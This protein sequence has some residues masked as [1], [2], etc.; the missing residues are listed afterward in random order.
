MKYYKKI[1][2]I[3]LTLLLF[4]GG[5]M[6]QTV[7][8][9]P[10][11]G[12][13]NGATPFLTIQAAVDSVLANAATPDVVQLQTNGIHIQTASVV[14]DMIGGDFT[15]IGVGGNAVIVGAN[16][17]AL[18]TDI[19]EGAV[20][21]AAT[22]STVLFEN[23]T[24]IPPSVLATGDADGGPV[25]DDVNG[26]SGLVM[27]SGSVNTSVT[28]RNLVITGNNN[29][30]A[31]T[32]IDGSLDWNGVT[33]VSVWPAA[34]AR[35]N[36]STDMAYI[37][38]DCVMSQTSDQALNVNQNVSRATNVAGPS[39]VISGT[40]VYS[41]ASNTILDLVP[42]SLQILG[43]ASGAINIH[44]GLEH[45]IQ[46]RKSLTVVLDNVSIH[47]HGDDL[48]DRGIYF[49]Y[50][51]ATYGCTMTN[52]NFWEVMGTVVRIDIRKAEM[53]PGGDFVV[54]NCHWRGGGQQG[55][56]GVQHTYESGH[57]YG[58]WGKVAF[59]DC[60][61]IGCD[62]NAMRIRS[63]PELEVRNCVFDS[64]GY[65]QDPPTL[66]YG[67]STALLREYRDEHSRILVQDCTFTNNRGYGLSS[68]AQYC[69]YRNSYFEN[70]GGPA[71]L[72]GG[73]SVGP[74]Q[75]NP[76]LNYSISETLVEDCTSIYDGSDL[77]FSAN[78]ENR[79]CA[80]VFR[81]LSLIMR[82]TRIEGAPLNSVNVLSGR[83]ENQTVLLENVA[84]LFGASTA[85]RLESATNTLIGCSVW[86]CDGSGIER[87]I[88]VTD[89]ADTT[90]NNNP[91]VVQDCFFGQC[92]GNGILTG[93]LYDG[94]LSVSNSMVQECSPSGLLIYSA[95]SMV[96]DCTFWNNFQAGAWLGFG[97]GPNSLIDYVSG[98]SFLGNGL[99]GL[100]IGEAQGIVGPATE[101]F[102]LPIA[103]VTG[104]TFLDNGS[105]IYIDGIG[106][107]QRIEIA[108]CIAA[109]VGDIGLDVGS[110]S[111]P[112]VSLSY[113]SLVTAG[114]N[115]LTTPVADPNSKVTI[116]LG[117]VNL[118]PM[119]VGINP[120]GADFFVVDNNAFISL[121]S[122]GGVLVGSGSYRGNV[123]DV[124]AWRLY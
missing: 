5:V 29:A 28:L 25:G 6:A 118:D 97:S 32:S 73:Q 62:C 112:G 30:N 60:S 117:Y 35:L 69:T 34:C 17:T 84:V 23:L 36:A 78:D 74:E 48:G 9:D 105:N 63:F 96:Q 100:R 64:C 47:D 119:L 103:S 41:Y 81:G 92:D 68:E 3:V 10:I 11:A 85:F 21:C 71:F 58:I 2:P 113:S 98:C 65:Y 109:G 120:V 13:D 101:P 26:M 49:L 91:L 89:I 8:V 86:D 79:R 72:G 52:C 122:D 123:N 115:T 102:S 31:P 44:H 80:T 46:L 116:G 88:D 39:L 37:V 16:F 14:I 124:A 93:A 76:L 61:F 94:S 108:N 42:I 99:Y 77:A 87:F 40:G 20:I 75:T 82:N 15:M 67:N 111:G 95:T 57:A 38:E 45:A 22:N 1:I 66:N 121:G 114:A 59:T 7:V 51:A 24:V 54:T 53:G 55:W 56:F 19:D 50:N 33:T 27:H 104:C 4:T 43:D 90:Q 106:I 12:T 110:M 18:S 107:L 70:N 83:N